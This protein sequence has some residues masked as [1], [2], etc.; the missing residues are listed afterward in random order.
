MFSAYGLSLGEAFQMRDDIL[1]AFGDAAVT[2]KPVGGDFLEGKRTPLLAYAFEN[3]SQMQRKVLDTVGEELM[4]VEQVQEV[5][6]A[7]GAVTYME[8]RIS[9]LHDEAV[10][11]L[12]ESELAGD[13]YA[14]LVA[15][16]EVAT[17]RQR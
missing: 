17:K 16:A 2:G 14:E 11:A 1:G 7:T 6:L 5:V 10:N 4:N 12:Q 3:A 8:S 9:Q 15:L 13:S